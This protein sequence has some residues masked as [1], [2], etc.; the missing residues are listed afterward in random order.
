MAD[1]ARR[2]GVSLSTV[3]YV[4]SGRRPVSEATRQRV[5][6]AMEAL[7]YHPHAVA[8]SLR[9]RRSR[10]IALIFPPSLAKGLIETQLEFV[11]SAA[12][13]ASQEGYNLLLWTAPTDDAG[14]VRMTR[15]GL[16]DGLI[17]MEI[18]A[19]DSR[20]EMLKARNYPFT[21]IGRCR[22]N[23]GVSFVDLDMDHA[24]RTCLCYLADLGHRRVAFVNYSPALFEA[25]YGP[26]VY[27]W[28]SFHQLVQEWGLAGQAVLCDTTPQAGYEATRR[29]L[30]ERP[31]PT[32]IFT[33]NE[34]AIGGITQAILEVGLKI[35]DDI[36]FVALASPRLAEVTSP[37]LTTL[38]F[39]AAEEGR[40]A[41]EMLI[42]RLE[43]DLT[44]PTQVLVQARL[45]VRQ[46]SG[47]CRI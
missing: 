14:I 38:D 35:P 33:T 41:T 37:A 5:L 32:A 47:P 16:I 30:D 20:V 25:G 43:E 19:H 1:I 12:A 18:K 39:P 11:A 7:D 31:A 4:L 28:E 46:S 23:T 27:F 9:S 15:Q 29:L 8:R 6:Q 42:R 13:V 2:A 40:V 36:S 21:M 17:L 44:E 10:A 24:M 34:R 3:S 26:A 22:D 45:T